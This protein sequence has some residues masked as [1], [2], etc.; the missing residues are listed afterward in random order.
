MTEAEKQEQI[1]KLRKGV[2]LANKI[3][4][5]CIVLGVV[6]VGLTYLGNMLYGTEGLYLQFL[7][8]V[9]QFLMLDM[10]VMIITITVKIGLAARYNKY[11]RDE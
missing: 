3:R 7:Q 5:L 1:N 6:L 10:V 4:F 8:K 2:E 11:L 9:H